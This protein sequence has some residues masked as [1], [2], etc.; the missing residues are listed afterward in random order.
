MLLVRSS[1]DSV[2]SCT[3]HSD[4]GNSGSVRHTR[5]RRSSSSVRWIARTFPITLRLV[6]VADEC[7]ELWRLVAAW[8]IVS[9]VLHTL[10]NLSNW[11][12]RQGIQHATKV[13]HFPVVAPVPAVVCAPGRLAEVIEAPLN[14]NV[15]SW[16]ADITAC[17]KSTMAVLGLTLMQSVALVHHTCLTHSYLLNRQD[18]PEC[19]H[20]DC[21]LTVAHVLLECNHYNMVRQRYFNVSSLHELF[22]RSA[23]KRMIYLL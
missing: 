2:S 21:A 10:H 8:Y 23:P 22:A 15:A 20:C 9:K 19:S 18:Q 1:S 17:L 16:T 7:W 11:K 13:A 5:S 14:A 6:K 4:V 12:E 3:F